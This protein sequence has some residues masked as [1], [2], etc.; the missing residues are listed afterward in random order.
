MARRAAPIPVPPP[1]SA[2]PV[3]WKDAPLAR[4]VFVLHNLM[5]RVADRLVADLGLTGSR[6]QLLGALVT[7]DE[8]PSLTQ[9]TS[10]GLL[11][12][13]NVSRMVA[14]MEED[15]LV[16][17]FQ[18]AGGG[19]TVYVRITALGERIRS[20]ACAR[21]TR[22]SESFLEGMDGSE[23]RS[24]QDR[25]DAMIRSMERLESVL[26]HEAA[27]PADGSRAKA[28]QRSQRRAATK[29]N[30]AQKNTRRVKA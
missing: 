15:G 20:E 16:E 4:E 9:L 10:D 11:T 21:G 23:I 7:Y 8:P 14:A 28:G 2:D 12:L 26:A 13:Q 19:R 3:R 27:A 1:C 24:M 18:R 22:F 25:L 6:W 29:K 5:M 17:R 30:K